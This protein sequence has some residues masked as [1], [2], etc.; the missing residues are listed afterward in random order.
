MISL[1]RHSGCLPNTLKI[2]SPDLF[3]KFITMLLTFGAFCRND[4]WSLFFFMVVSPTR[5]QEIERLWFQ[6]VLLTVCTQV[7]AA[8]EDAPLPFPKESE[9]LLPTQYCTNWCAS[10]SVTRLL[11]FHNRHQRKDWSC[12]CID[13]L[14]PN[15]AESKNWLCE[16][17]LDDS[18]SLFFPS[19]ASWFSLSSVPHSHSLSFFPREWYLWCFKSFAR[20]YSKLFDLSML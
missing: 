3:Q 19:L 13:W 4:L 14:S 1:L 6:T 7:H 9:A 5:L 2:Q 15:W 17:R 12:L 10:R 20:S 8:R 16:S 18:R 11:C